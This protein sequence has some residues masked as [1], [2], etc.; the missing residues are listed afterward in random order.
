MSV[1]MDYIISGV[2]F[3]VLALTIARVQSNLNSS[4]YQNTYSFQ[5]QGNAVELGRQLEHD[6]LKMGYHV[7]TQ[8]IIYADSV[9]IVFKADL[10]ND[11]THH[12]P[13]VNAL[14]YWA[15]TTG[16]G[17]YSSNPRDFPLFRSEDGVTTT[18]NWG[19]IAFNISYF[20]GSGNQIPGPITSSSVLN[21]IKGINVKLRIESSDSVYAEE[22]YQWPAVAWEKLMFPRNLS[23]LNY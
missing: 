18:Q 21:T 11:T 1:I 20:D 16:Q 7:S 17:G 2:L 10:Y 12:P 6:F 8:K 19:L 15:G 23:N 9:K 3:G 4:V 13:T 14:S 22:G 5:V